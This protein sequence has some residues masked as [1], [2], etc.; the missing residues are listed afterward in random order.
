MFLHPWQLQLLPQ[1]RPN[2]TLVHLVPLHPLMLHPHLWVSTSTRFPCMFWPGTKF[3]SWAIS[4][5]FGSICSFSLGIN[6]SPNNTSFSFSLNPSN[7][8]SLLR[9]PSSLLESMSNLNQNK[10][11]PVIKPPLNSFAIAVLSILSV[12]SEDI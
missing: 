7:F 11:L 9:S 6:G 3:C 2:L 12:W 1:R 8:P 4:P 10:R 5:K